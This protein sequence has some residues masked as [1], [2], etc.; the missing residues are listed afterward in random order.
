M[1]RTISDFMQAVLSIQ[2]SMEALD[3]VHQEVARMKEE[4][5]EEKDPLGVLRSNIG[6]CFGEGMSIPHRRMWAA[7]C[8]AEH[9]GFGPEYTNRDFTPEEAFQAGVRLAEGRIR[10]GMF[11]KVDLRPTA[12]QHLLRDED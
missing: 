7:V 11:V 8:G 3:F 9:P 6:F 4:H 10:D 5:P 2:G 1:P 12:W